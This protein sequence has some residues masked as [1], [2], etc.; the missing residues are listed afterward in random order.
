MNPMS[1]R[2]DRP[3]GYGGAGGKRAQAVRV[4]DEACNTIRFGRQLQ[5]AA[6]GHVEVVEPDH[7]R[8]KDRAAQTLPQSPQALGLAT[9]GD[10]DEPGRVEAEGGQAGSIKVEIGLAPQHRPLG[11]QASD[12]GRA[13]AEDSAVIHRPRHL[14]E[15]AAGETSSKMTVKRRKA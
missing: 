13:E 1:S 12:Q 11:G 9:G 15:A 5:A 8:R 3:A 6:G 10:D 7:R 4:Q 14:M 2:D